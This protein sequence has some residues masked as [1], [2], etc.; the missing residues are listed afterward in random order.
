MIETIISLIVSLAGVLAGYLFAVRGAKERKQKE[1]AQRVVL[2]SEVAAFRNKLVHDIVEQDLPQEVWSRVFDQI[3]SP[4]IITSGISKE[5]VERQFSTLK[6]QIDRIEA[7][8]PDEATID[9]VATVNEAILANSV[10]R[11]AESLR[12]LEEKLLTKWDVARIVFTIIGALG[13]L[14][15]L[16]LTIIK[17][18][19]G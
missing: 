18:A 14:I 6:E 1:E 10:E 3:M 8:F 19:S 9:K 15:A 17:F 2:E 12:R 4:L 7:R 13:G 5:E 16:T 11:L